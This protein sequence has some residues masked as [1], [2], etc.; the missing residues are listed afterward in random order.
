[1]LYDIT[2]AILPDDTPR[3]RRT[4]PPTSQ[5]AADKSQ[6]TLHQ[7]KL[8]VLQIVAELGNL[9]GT[10]INQAYQ[11]QFV[12]RGWKRVSYD[13]PRKRAGE[14]AADGYLDV[15]YHGK[16]LN[17]QPEAVYSLPADFSRWVL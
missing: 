13:S 6:P 3:A 4:D 9:T 10:E 16:G 14:L 8:A 15:L 17:N 5:K 7:V 12:R 2:P 1:M 11:D